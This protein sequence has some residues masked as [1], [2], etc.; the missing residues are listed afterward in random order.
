MVSIR[1]KKKV[2]NLSG[3]LKSHGSH[4]PFGAPPLC[5]CHALPSCAR[6]AIICPGFANV[7]IRP[8]N[9]SNGC[10]YANR[11]RTKRASEGGGVDGVER[12]TRHVTPSNQFISLIFPNV[13]TKGEKGRLWRHVNN[14]YHL[15]RNRSRLARLYSWFLLGK[16]SRWLASGCAWLKIIQLNTN[17]ALDVVIGWA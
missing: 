11:H 1:G 2:L 12:H 17:S 8:D 16:S 6:V 4:L 9:G 14:R 3:G 13:L 5:I 15:T 7:A 10:N